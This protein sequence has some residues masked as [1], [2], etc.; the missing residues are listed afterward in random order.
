MIKQ[1]N[2]TITSTI[3]EG[4]NETLKGFQTILIKTCEYMIAQ[5]MSIINLNMINTI[6]ATLVEQ[7]VPQKPL[8]PNHQHPAISQQS[9]ILPYMSPTTP[10]STQPPHHSTEEQPTPTEF[11]QTVKQLNA[12]RKQTDPP[13]SEEVTIN[14]EATPHPDTI[15]KEQ[16]I[17]NTPDTRTSARSSKLS[18]RDNKEKSKLSSK[19]T[20]SRLGKTCK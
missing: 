5:Q 2:I 16:E 7:I 1:N 10:P 12:K 18:T 19:Q 13:D 20:L 8:T 6:K 3:K 14:I 11:I 17:P 9:N 4:V 15:M